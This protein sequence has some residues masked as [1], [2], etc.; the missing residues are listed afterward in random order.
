MT[1]EKTKLFKKNL[2]CSVDGKQFFVSAINVISERNQVHVVL[3][4][5]TSNAPIT[6]SQF[7]VYVQIP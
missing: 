1:T 6:L 7:A 2:K 5:V 4:A 3:K